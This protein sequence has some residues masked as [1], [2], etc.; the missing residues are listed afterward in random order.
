MQQQDSDRV[1]VT[2]ALDRQGRVVNVTDADGKRREGRIYANKI[3]A[4]EGRCPE[5]EAE[6]S[7]VKTIEV[8]YVTCADIEDPC[9]VFDP[10]TR[11]WYYVC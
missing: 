2:I 1:F 7:A 11:R 9:W 4:I 5:G 6:I 10:L 3:P 8:T